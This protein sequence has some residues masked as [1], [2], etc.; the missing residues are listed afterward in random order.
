MFGRSPTELAL[1]LDRSKH[2]PSDKRIAQLLRLRGLRLGG[3]LAGR[4]S[5]GNRP[6]RRVSS[7]ASQ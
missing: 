6:N 4:P 5:L 2:G 1:D 3:S 7:A